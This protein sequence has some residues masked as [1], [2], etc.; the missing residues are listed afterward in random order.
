MHSVLLRMGAPRALRQHCRDQLQS[1]LR[2]DSITK[3]H[4]LMLAGAIL[5]HS[6]P[7][8]DTTYSAYSTKGLDPFYTKRNPDLKPTIEFCQHE[9]TLHTENARLW[10]R[11]CIE[12]VNWCRKMPYRHFR[13]I[14]EKELDD[15]VLGSKYMKL[16]VFFK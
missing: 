10:V 4:R 16:N 1:I 12:V 7:I 15:E 2:F 9:G 5:L 6:E 13:W 11:F 8:R 14:C 3:M